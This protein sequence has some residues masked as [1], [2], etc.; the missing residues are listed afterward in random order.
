MET[1]LNDSKPVLRKYW[2]DA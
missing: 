1:G 2:Y